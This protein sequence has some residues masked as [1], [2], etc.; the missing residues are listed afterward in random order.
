MEHQQIS[1]TSFLKNSVVFL[2]GGVSISGVV[3]AS[4]IVRIFW[5]H[6]KLGGRKSGSNFCGVEN[7]NEVDSCLYL[8]HSEFKRSTSLTP[9]ISVNQL[10]ELHFCG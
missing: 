8:K 4:K 2:S 10:V 6:K 7:S 3:V 9:E 1:K 5:L